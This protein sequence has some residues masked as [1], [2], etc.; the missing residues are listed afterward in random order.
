MLNL[1]LREEAVKGQKEHDNPSSSHVKW[2]ETEQAGVRVIGMCD[3]H[4]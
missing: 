3:T 2:K 1:C 4:P